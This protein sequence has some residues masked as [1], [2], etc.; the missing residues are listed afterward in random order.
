[1]TQEQ[2]ELKRQQEI[3]EINRKWSE[4][5]QEQQAEIEK[6]QETIEEFFS[7]YEINCKAQA[8]LIDQNKLKEAVRS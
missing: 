3:Q 2:E 6:K 4:I 5:V 8:V 7:T 1:M